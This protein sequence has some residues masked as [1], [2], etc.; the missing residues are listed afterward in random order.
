MYLAW[1]DY[2]EDSKSRLSCQNCVFNDRNL[3]CGKCKMTPENTKND[4]SLCT[5]KKYIFH[6]SIGV[7][8]CHSRDTNETF[9]SEKPSVAIILKLSEKWPQNDWTSIR[10]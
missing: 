8:I 9:C 4:T 10:T 7:L 3:I 1:C 2:Y 5:S 6:S